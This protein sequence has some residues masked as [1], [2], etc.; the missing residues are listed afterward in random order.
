MR[1]LTR[2]WLSTTSRHSSA[3]ERNACSIWRNDSDCVKA[4]PHIDG[5]CITV[6]S[7]NVM[8]SNQNLPGQDVP[9]MQYNGHRISF[10]HRMSIC[11]WQ[12]RLSW[13][14]M[15]LIHNSNN[16]NTKTEPCRT[17]TFPSFKISHICS[18]AVLS[19]ILLVHRHTMRMWKA[20]QSSPTKYYHC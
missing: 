4:T 14:V 16:N 3:S 6:T 13:I 9:L 5:K 8:H 1:S 20:C 7:N 19:R 11:S 10:K 2:F 17:M 15:R 12:A 18:Y